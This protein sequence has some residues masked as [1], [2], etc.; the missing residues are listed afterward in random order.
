AAALVSCRCPSSLA[1]SPFW[2]LIGVGG[3]DAEP[4]G[5]DLARDGPGFLLV[6]PPRSGRS[7]AL[8]ALARGLSNR[9]VRVV[10]VGP[11]PPRSG[12]LSTMDGVTLLGPADGSALMAVV[13]DS[14]TAVLVDD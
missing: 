2:T 3:D 7:N 12:L 14:P 10:L 8:V 4:V 5:V 6:G 1:K 13:A 9:G 11:S